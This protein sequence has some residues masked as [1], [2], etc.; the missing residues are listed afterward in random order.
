MEAEYDGEADER[1]SGLMALP[2]RPP[3]PPGAPSEG[4][5]VLLRPGS[6]VAWL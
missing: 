6:D 4:D 1:G 3:P 2:E 5:D